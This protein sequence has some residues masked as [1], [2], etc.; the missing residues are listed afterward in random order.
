M[1]TMREIDY[2]R[3]EYVREMHTSAI[4][5]LPPFNGSRYVPGE[6]G[7][8]CPNVMV[9]GEAPGAQETVVGRPFVGPSGI[10]LRQLMRIA[11]LTTDS[12]SDAKVPNG[13]PWKVGGPGNAWITNVV[14]FR[15]PRNRTPLESEIV[16]ARPSLR[17]EWK[18]IGEPSVI[19]CIGSTALRAVTNK[20]LSNVSISST[21]VHYKNRNGNQ[22]VV[23]PMVHPSFVL[24]QG[25]AELRQRMGELSEADWERF[26][27]W[28]RKNNP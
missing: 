28:L 8:I 19:I 17:E 4:G 21:C 26:G 18:A 5:I 24:H 9:I 20:W 27:E 10:V 11:N 7:D 15:P 1:T 23:W 6:G 14:K 22:M 2:E 3:L 12:R 16:L 25:T 13:R